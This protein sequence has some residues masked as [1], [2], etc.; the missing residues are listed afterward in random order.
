MRSSHMPTL[1]AIEISTT[2]KM[3]RRMRPNHRACGIRQLQ[4]SMV[5]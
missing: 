1:R 2:V 5:Q 3:L 4:A